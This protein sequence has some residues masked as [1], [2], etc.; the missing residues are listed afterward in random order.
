MTLKIIN[1]ENITDISNQEILKH[2]PIYISLIYSFLEY[3][4]DLRLLLVQS[5]L[6]EP[7]ICNGAHIVVTFND[8]MR[9]FLLIVD[10][11]T[12]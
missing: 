5:F 1:V 7:Q 8:N 4:L 9:C 2:W 10:I 11:L 12:C 6:N 3:I